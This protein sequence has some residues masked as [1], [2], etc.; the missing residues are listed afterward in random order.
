[1]ARGSVASTSMARG[2]AAA[3]G[4]GPSGRGLSVSGAG[5]GGPV[6][7]G[8]MGGMDVGGGMGGGEG[9][10]DSGKGVP[11]PFTPSEAW[12]SGPM[13][14]AGTQSSLSS[15][16]ILCMSVHGEEAVVGSSDHALY[17]VDLSRPDKKGRTLYNKSMGHTEWVTCVCYLPDGRI[18]SGG[19]DS[20]LCLWDKGVVRCTDLR[21]H[22]GSVSA[23]AS[24]ASGELAVSCSYD[25]TLRLWN[26]GRK[27]YRELS[28]LMGHSAPVLGMAWSQQGAIASGARDGTAIIWDVGS[29][30][31]SR[32]LS[33]AHEGHLTSLCWLPA[34]GGASS[35]LLLTGGQDACLR[36]WDMRSAR[37]VCEAPQLHATPKGK[38]AIGDL[39]TVDA[40][41]NTLVVST[42]ADKAV[43]I[44]D[45]R[46]SFGVT[47]VSNHHPDFIYS[48]HAA[49]SLVFSGDGSGQLMVHDAA[50]GEVLYGLGANKAAVR[51]ICT[52]GDDRLVVSGDDGCVLIYRFK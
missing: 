12:Y 3:A 29:G 51:G 41:G 19:M 7:D 35:P 14:P 33:G 22:S 43:K 37:V 25:K 32:K 48:L 6:M 44:T 49:G 40:S 5:R 28:C 17:T 23:V 8:A 26:V 46:A 42:G 13:D 39:C 30:S 47:Y 27:P 9:P 4:G 21:G 15:V 38:G 24:G 10:F 1:M 20:K 18:L 11:I 50:R 16:P 45:P 34:L 31:A 52:A 2:S 36:A